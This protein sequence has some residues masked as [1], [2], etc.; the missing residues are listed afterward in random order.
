MTIRG[1]DSRLILYIV[2]IRKRLISTKEEMENVKK[3]RRAT[4][5]TERKRK[6][7]KQT[8]AVLFV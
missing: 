4:T 8:Q 3:K 2:Y 1:I 7:Q 5:T 6:K